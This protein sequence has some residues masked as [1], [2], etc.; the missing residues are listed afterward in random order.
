VYD[1]PVIELAR[2]LGSA[3]VAN[4]IML[5]ALVRSSGVVS[6]ESVIR[7]MEKTFTGSKAKLIDLNVS[8]FDKYELP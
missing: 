6:R 7:V 8:A 5:G 4:M 1:V 3:R 2:E